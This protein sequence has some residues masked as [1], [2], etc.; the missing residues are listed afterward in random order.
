VSLSFTALPD[1]TY[2]GTISE[3]AKSG[4]AN[5]NSVTFEVTVRIDQP[6]ANIKPGMTAYV[7]MEIAKIEDTLSVPVSAVYQRE[8]KYYVNI[9]QPDGS[10][11]QKEIEPGIVS[12]LRVQV[13]NNSL[14]T[15][16]EIQSN[17]DQVLDNAPVNPMMMR[18]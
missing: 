2:Q 7:S 6:D 11:F 4:I 1:K 10:F 13:L 5:N 17:V 9:K 16:M 15:S 3:I 8:G 12:G 18:F 14:D